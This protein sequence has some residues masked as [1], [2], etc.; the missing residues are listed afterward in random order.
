MAHEEG[1]PADDEPEFGDGCEARD[2]FILE[3]LQ[4]R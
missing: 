2:V 1:C 3:G 4:E